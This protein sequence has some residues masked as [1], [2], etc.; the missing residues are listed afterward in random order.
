MIIPIHQSR[1][2]CSP[3]HL[4]LFTNVLCDKLAKFERK[5]T[6]TLYPALII[7]A[8]PALKKAP[9]NFLAVQRWTKFSKLP[10]GA[11]HLSR[12]DEISFGGAQLDSIASPEENA[13]SLSAAPGTWLLA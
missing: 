3:K 2:N 6:S 5:M 9:R 11:T 12:T 1:P 4:F 13:N 8:G 10:L 7:N